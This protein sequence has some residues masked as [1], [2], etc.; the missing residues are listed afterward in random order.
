MS[1]ED[2]GFAIIDKETGKRYILKGLGE[3]VVLEVEENGFLKNRFKIP[4]EILK[5]LL[6]NLKGEE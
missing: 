3:L 1:F 5:A 4:Y 6:S 2:I